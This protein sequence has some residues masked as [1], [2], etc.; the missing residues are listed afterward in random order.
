[1]AQRVLGLGAR[2]LPPVVAAG[3]LAHRGTAQA[4]QQ[5]PSR[6]IPGRL[7]KF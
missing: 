6:L 3:A 5:V 1:M 4:R 2:A 7:L